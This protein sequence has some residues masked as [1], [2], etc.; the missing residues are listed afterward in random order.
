MSWKIVRKSPSSR[1]LSFPPITNFLIEGVVLLTGNSYTF[2]F[3][4][5][6]SR[7][8]SRGGTSW[9]GTLSFCKTCT[10][11]PFK[12]ASR[13]LVVLDQLLEARPQAQTG[14][15]MCPLVF[16]GLRFLRRFASSRQ[17]IIGIVAIGRQSRVSVIIARSLRTISHNSVGSWLALNDSHRWRQILMLNFE[18]SKICSEPTGR[19]VRSDL[20]KETYTQR[21]NT[22]TLKLV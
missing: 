17:R 20:S 11:P 1:Y 19:V 13:W 9:R 2:L 4:F 12:I 14:S 15:Y 7:R 16:F 21:I 5:L 22:P 3:H 6:G 18:K 10:M 8:I